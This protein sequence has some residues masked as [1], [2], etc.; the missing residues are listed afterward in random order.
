MQRSS[1]RFAGCALALCAGFAIAPAH[2]DVLLIERVEAAQD[3]ELPRRG[4]LMD[5]VE[6]RFGAPSQKHAPVGGDRPQHP[7]ITRWDYPT[8]SVYF[9]HTHVVNSVLAKSKPLETHV[10]PVG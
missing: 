2:A 9:E 7:P 5:S 10:K 3:V 1:I 8:F 4:E 6:R